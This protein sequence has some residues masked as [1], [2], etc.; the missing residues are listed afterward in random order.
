MGFSSFPSNY[1]SSGG[2]HFR[3]LI[4]C[5]ERFLNKTKYVTKIFEQEKEF[6]ETEVCDEARSSGPKCVMGS[7]YVK[8]KPVLRKNTAFTGPITSNTTTRATANKE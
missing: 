7:I 4:D 5:K 1:S 6:S 3:Y 2:L 8:N